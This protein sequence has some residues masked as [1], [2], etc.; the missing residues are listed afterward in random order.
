MY[1]ISVG[2]KE[3]WGI[4]G[5]N[6]LLQFSKRQPCAKQCPRGAKWR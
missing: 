5:E 3:F 2:D 1:W 6:D 4:V